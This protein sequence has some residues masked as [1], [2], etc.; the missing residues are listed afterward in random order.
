MVVMLVMM[1][2]TT[3]D[4]MVDNSWSILDYGHIQIYLND[5]FIHTK[6]FQILL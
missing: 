5:E 2:M 4:N 3:P 1:P 6:K